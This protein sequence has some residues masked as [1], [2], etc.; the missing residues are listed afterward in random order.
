[1]EAIVLMTPLFVLISVL[2]GML[3][4]LRV[5][6]LMYVQSGLIPLVSTTPPAD[7]ESVLT[8]AR[9]TIIHNILIEHA[10]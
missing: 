1:M 7:R 2:M 4:L 10:P 9:K 5:F 8:N 3:M 6:V